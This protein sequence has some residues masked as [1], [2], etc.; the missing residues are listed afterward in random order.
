MELDLQS[1]RR[2]PDSVQKVCLSGCWHL[3]KR[4]GLAETG[5]KGEKGGVV[6]MCGG[7]VGGKEETYKILF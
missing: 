5:L 1:S 4:Q 3:A 2:L 6:E 7:G